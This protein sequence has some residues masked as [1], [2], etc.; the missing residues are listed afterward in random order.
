[1][2]QCLRCFLWFFFRSHRFSPKH[3]GLAYI[4]DRFNFFGFGHRLPYIIIGQLITSLTYIIIAIYPP[5]LGT[6]W[7]IYLA[8]YVFRGFSMTLAA[9]AHAGYIVDAQIRDR[10]GFLQSVRAA[11]SEFLVTSLF[12]R[13][14]PPPHFCKPALTLFCPLPAA[15]F[16]LATVVQGGAQI[17]TLHG[18]MPAFGL[19]LASAVSPFG[20]FFPPPL[21][22]A[23]LF[24]HSCTP[25]HTHTRARSVVL[26]L[27]LLGLLKEEKETV[28]VKKAEPFDWNSLR[29]IIEP[30]GMAIVFLTITGAVGN[31]M[32][33]FLIN[34]YLVNQRGLDLVDIGHL[35]TVSLVVNFPGSL[36]AAYALDNWDVRGI[37]FWMNAITALTTLALLWIPD[38]FAFGYNALLNLIGSMTGQAAQTLI[39]G[40]ALRI[41]PPKVGASFLAIIGTLLS[42]M[43][44]LANYISGFVVANIIQSHQQLNRYQTSF[45]IGGIVIGAGCLV[46][47]LLGTA[48]MPPCMQEEEK[49]EAAAAKPNPLAVAEGGGVVEP[50]VEGKAV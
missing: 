19:L 29:L 40:V 32:G 35:G 6:G 12:P 43:G 20:A 45:I 38:N 44:I 27:T 34:L 16:G 15:M 42:G 4:T 25:P 13:P 31:V 11:G 33:N 3:R 46:I 9:S 36:L 49:E 18:F 22:V 37:M 5:T 21:C 41:A 14:F 7:I 8:M 1:M 26:P 10:I 2:T 39:A 23:G 47:P 48:A 50:V 24:L 28:V 30:K 17:V